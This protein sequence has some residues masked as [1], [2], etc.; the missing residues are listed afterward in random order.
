MLGELFRQAR[1]DRGRTQADLCEAYGVKH[2]SQV[3]H[4]ERGVS[5]SFEQAVRVC[6]TLDLDLTDVA[7]QVVADTP[8]S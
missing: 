2:S 8:D 4:L 5:I 7:T 1:L 6:R 3:S